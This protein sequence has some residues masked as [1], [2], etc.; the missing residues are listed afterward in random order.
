MSKVIAIIQA[1]MRS[2]RLPGKALAD[3][4]GKPVLQLMIERVRLARSVDQIIIATTENSPGIELWC[5]RNK[6]DCFVGNEN[7][8]LERVYETARVFHA[9]VIVDLTGDCP[10]VDP[11]H[12]D[13]LVHFIIR[14]GN[15]YA[16]NINPRAWPDGFDVQVYTKQVLS[17]LHE[18]IK[19]EAYRTHTGWNINN[20]H[21]DTD[22]FSRYNL[23]PRYAWHHQPKM[24]LTLDY[25]EDLEVIASVVE[26][27]AIQQGKRYYS[28]EDIIDYVLNNGDI[29]VNQLCKTKKPGEG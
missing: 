8:V 22:A 2:T 16:S 5:A 12:I 19:S 28:A 13:R 14:T 25:A 11:S 20:P 23:P 26:Y 7:D 10:L 1:R 15:D 24:R 6:I 9:D 29:L 3:I 4:H 17:Y 27:F 18:N 21:L